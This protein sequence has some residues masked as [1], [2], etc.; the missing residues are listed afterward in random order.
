MTITYGPLVWPIPKNLDIFTF[1]AGSSTSSVSLH[2]CRISADWPDRLLAVEAEEDIWIIRYYHFIS[3][4]PS[5]HSYSCKKRKWILPFS[6]LLILGDFFVRNLY[7]YSAPV[8]LKIS[9]LLFDQ[10][11]NQEKCR[12]IKWS[13]HSK[14]WYFWSF[15]FRLGYWSREMWKYVPIG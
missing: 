11:I 9:V 6:S 14:N 13:E 10:F 4:I 5:V 1:D 2:I 15:I 8:S 3:I 7:L 12:K